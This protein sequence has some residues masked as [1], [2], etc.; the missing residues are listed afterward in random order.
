MES[1]FNIVELIENN[2]ITKLSNTYQNKLLTS[3]KEEFT[4][5]EQQIFVASFYGFLK[6]DSQ[7]DFVVDF[8]PYQFMNIFLEEQ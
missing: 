8:D 5:Y 1:G 2:P 4:D 7:D 6:Y 3:I